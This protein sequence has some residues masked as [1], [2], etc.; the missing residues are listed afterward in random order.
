MPVL[1]E[2]SDAVIVPPH[3]LWTREECAAME[4]AGL[5]DLE[6]YELIRGD[7]VLKM[8]KN[9]PHMLSAL[10]LVTWLQ[11][12]FGPLHVIQ[13]PSIDVHPEDNPTSDPEPDAVVLSRSVRELS[14]PPRPDDLNLVAEV[15]STTLAF[16]LTVKARLYARA[17][18]AEYWTIDVQGRRLIVHRRPEGGKYLVVAAYSEDEQVATLAA[19]GHTIRVADLF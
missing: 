8:G 1:V 19:P 12:V 16:D 7:L 6:R 2:Y 3:K 18:I 17:G 5:L 13:K 10:L 15:S 9:Y 11:R 4:R 14:A